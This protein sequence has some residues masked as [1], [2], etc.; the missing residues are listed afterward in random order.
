MYPSV[1]SSAGGTLVAF[2]SYCGLALMF[3]SLLPGQGTVEKQCLRG[4][5]V[6]LR[7]GWE[8]ENSYCC[9]GH[10]EVA[11]AQGCQG[12]DPGT[13]GMLFSWAG[14]GGLYFPRTRAS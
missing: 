2:W 13:C 14:F 8:Q 6:L 4:A 12:P 9:E 3:A 11:A 1:Q 5:L 7:N 10:Q